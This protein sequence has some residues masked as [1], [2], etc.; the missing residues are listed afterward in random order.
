MGQLERYGSDLGGWTG[1]YFS[2]LPKTFPDRN[3]FLKLSFFQVEGKYLA[4]KSL[5]INKTCIYFIKQSTR[6]IS[7]QAQ[8]YRDFRENGSQESGLND[9]GVK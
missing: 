1:A 5:K 7:S 3:L 9:F 2:N 8:C 6:K 4:P